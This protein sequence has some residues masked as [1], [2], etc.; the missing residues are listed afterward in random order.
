V[1]RIMIQHVA[2]AIAEVSHL[3]SLLGLPKKKKKKKKKYLWLRWSPQLG[4][5]MENS[6]GSQIIIGTACNARSEQR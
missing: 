6:C 2:D 3:R 4:L 1:P 5:S